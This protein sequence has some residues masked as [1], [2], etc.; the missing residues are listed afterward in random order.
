[1]E[2]GFAQDQKGKEIGPNKFAPPV[3][4][5]CSGRGKSLWRACERF[6]AAAKRLDVHL[7][8][9][10]E[11]IPYLS[12]C[13]CKDTKKSRRMQVFHLFFYEF[14]TY[15]FSIK[16]SRRLFAV[17]SCSSL[18]W[19]IQIS[20]LRGFACPRA[21]EMTG[22][23]A[24]NVRRIQI[25]MSITL[26]FGVLRLRTSSP[27]MERFSESSPALCIITTSYISMVLLAF[28]LKI[29]TGIVRRTLSCC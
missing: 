2:K 1:M 25:P 26:L 10:A 20:V 21:F 3:A 7:L 9:R 29:R 15:S 17:A 12:A 19:R 22:S 5:V 28:S 8:R 11:Q 13:C 16:P 23:T 24:L 18:S 14:P 27:S 6:A 4:K